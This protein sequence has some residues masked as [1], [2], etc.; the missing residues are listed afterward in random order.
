MFQALVVVFKVPVAGL[1]GKLQKFG[2]CFVHRFLQREAHQF[3]RHTSRSITST[4]ISASSSRMRQTRFS[5][6]SVID[7]LLI[8]SHDFGG[9][10][11]HV[12]HLTRK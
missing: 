11:R 7:F 5:N 4:A 12:C 10:V 3:G 9:F 1:G 8:K 2:I 6:G